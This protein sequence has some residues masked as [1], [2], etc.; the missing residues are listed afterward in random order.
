VIGE[1]EMATLLKKCKYVIQVVEG[2]EM[3]CSRLAVASMPV[4]PS[5]VPEKEKAKSDFE[6]GLYQMDV[7]EEHILDAAK[8][9]ICEF[10]Y[11]RAL[12]VEEATSKKR[13]KAA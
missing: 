7:C 5:S 8:E 4:P 12:E 13:K 3:S 10:E 11:F 1:T 6:W 2:H 9:I